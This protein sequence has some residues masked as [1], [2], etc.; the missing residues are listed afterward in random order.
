[1]SFH[2]N[3][4]VQ[5]DEVRRHLGSCDALDAADVAIYFYAHYP[6][7]SLTMMAD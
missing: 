6:L 5:D 2:A 1:M 7:A 3:A 4:T